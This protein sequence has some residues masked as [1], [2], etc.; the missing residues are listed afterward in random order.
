MKRN[1][2]QRVIGRRQLPRLGGRATQ[3][4]N[5]RRARSN[6]KQNWKQEAFREI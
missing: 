1:K 4:H 3:C 6:S 2:S 5:T